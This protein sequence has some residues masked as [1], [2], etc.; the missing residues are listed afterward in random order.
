MCEKMDPTK[1]T[2]IIRGQLGEVKMHILSYGNLL[3]GS[4]SEMEVK[5][6]KKCKKGG[7]GGKSA[8]EKQVK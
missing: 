7:T 2:G 8:S 1:L 3:I 6:V 4:K 5:K